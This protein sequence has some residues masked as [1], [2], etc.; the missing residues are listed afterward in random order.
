ML[1]SSAATLWIQFH[2]KEEIFLNCTHIPRELDTLTQKIKQ[3]KG[4]DPNSLASS[5]S[6]RTWF[7]SFI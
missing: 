4:Q 1:T 2:T 5:S 3:Y 6:Q 7:S